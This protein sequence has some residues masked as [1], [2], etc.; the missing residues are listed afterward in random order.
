LR[1]I[2][3]VN[4]KGGVGKTTT[5]V[6]LSAGLATLGKK[7]LLI[8]LDP[9]ANAT[10]SFGINLYDLKKSTYSVL[11]AVNKPD[12]SIIKVRENLYLLP[13]NIDLAGAEVEFSS[14]VGREYILKDAMKNTIDFDFIFVDC[15]P[16]M[17]LLNINAL[18]YV[19]EIFIPIQ[20]EFFALQGVSLLLKTIE[21]V[22][23]RLNPELTLSGVIM[24]MFDAR[25]ILSRDVAKEIEKFFSNEFPLGNP[26]I[27]KTF[28][29][30]NVK[31]AEA[32]SFGKSIFDYA[33]DSHGA[34]DYINLAKE[35]LGIEEAM[36][37][38]RQNPFPPS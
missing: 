10:L 36:Q 28:I 5:A 12:E 31:L 23:K 18:S 17:G 8:D 25:K 4:Q 7:I 29:R 20:C 37:T 21:L 16:S 26:K 35:V 2:A 3:L 9:Q 1:K 14:A 13:S 32:P 24:C 19:N 27:F 22:R 38:T 34:Y 33:P 15:P 6:N 11:T 30:T